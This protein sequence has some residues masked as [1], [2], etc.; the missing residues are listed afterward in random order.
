MRGMGV[1]LIQEKEL[2]G[3]CNGENQRKQEEKAA[4]RWLLQNRQ[5]DD[6]HVDLSSWSNRHEEQ[7]FI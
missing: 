1:A 5:Q 6:S 2:S 7:I 4:A 3:L